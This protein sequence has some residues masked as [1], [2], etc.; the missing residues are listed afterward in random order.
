VVVTGMGCLSALGN[1]RATFWRSLAEGRSGIA[2]MCRD[3]ETERLGAGDH[4]WVGAAVQGFD[5]GR[6]FDE[7]RLAVLDPFAQFAVVAAREAV[8]QSGLDL[9]GSPGERTAVVF[10]TGVG[11]D[12]SRDDTCFQCYGE[13]RRLP[14]FTI[15]RAMTNAATSHLCIDLGVTGP[16][17]TLSDA[18]A[19][20]THAIGLAF[21]LIRHGVVDAAVTGGSETL[22]STGLLKAWGTMRTMAPDTCRPFS[23]NRKGLVLGEGAGV[24]ILETLSSARRRGVPILAEVIGYG[25]SSDARDLVVPSAYG[26]AAALRGALRDARLGP[27]EV[28]YVNAHGTGTRLNDVTETR[29]IKEVFGDAARRLS[30]SS[31]KSMHGHA[32]GAAG[33]LELIATVEAVRHG[34]VPPTLH[35]DEPDPECD[36]DY[37]PNQARERDFPVALS[38]SFGFGGHNGVLAVRRAPL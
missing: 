37:T 24:L 12:Q 28:G 35:Y 9:R 11:G 29:A 17:Y 18:C 19:S 5:C 4:R 33:A 27:E 6:H 21:Q 1:D 7:R 8:A 13:H 20:A 10:G 38:S 22:P 34:V 23:R 30:I 32:L 14:P 16:S 26:I 15:L 25:S 36:L 3:V 2:T 31:T